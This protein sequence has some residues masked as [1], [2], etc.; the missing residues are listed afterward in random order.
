MPLFIFGVL[1]IRGK[2]VIVCVYGIG[3]I[4]A[5]LHAMQF[6][7]YFVVSVS[8]PF[9]VH[10]NEQHYIGEYMYFAF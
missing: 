2:N 1:T 9:K 3:Y 5:C 10:E 8:V 6:V 4:V 7:V